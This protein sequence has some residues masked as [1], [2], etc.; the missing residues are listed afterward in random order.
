MWFKRQRVMHIMCRKYIL[1]NIVS[2]QTLWCEFIQFPLRIRKLPSYIF[3]HNIVCMTG[4]PFSLFVNFNW[5]LDQIM[6]RAVC[7]TFLP[8][9]NSVTIPLFN[10]IYCELQKMMLHEHQN[11]LEIIAYF[12]WLSILYVIKLT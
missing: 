1:F 12:P 4:F 2:Y 3:C 7:F 6:K 11:V 8:V 9:R 5:I 10:F